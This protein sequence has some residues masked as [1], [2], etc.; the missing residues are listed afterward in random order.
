MHKL[1]VQ[2][3]KE[4]KTWVLSIIDAL[5]ECNNKTPAPE[6]LSVL[7]NIS[8]RFKQSNSLPPQILGSS[9]PPTVGRSD[10]HFRP[11]RSLAG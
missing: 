6:V 3:L 10:G 8:L 4:S 11:L 7:G 1:V 9:S 5:D 2:P